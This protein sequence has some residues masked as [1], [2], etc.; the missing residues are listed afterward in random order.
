MRISAT[1]RLLP[2][3]WRL[4][5]SVLREVEGQH[6]RFG[7]R[8]LDFHTAAIKCGLSDESDLGIDLAKLHTLVIFY[9]KF[10]DAT[11][12]AIRVEQ[13]GAFRTKLRLGAWRHRESEN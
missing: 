3:T 6:K 1:E 4:G 13:R 5:M 8:V 10:P 12:S 2:R 7:T 9:F 11:A